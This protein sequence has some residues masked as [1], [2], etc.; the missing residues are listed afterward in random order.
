MCTCKVRFRPV[1]MALTISGTSIWPLV[2]QATDTI[3]LTMTGIIQAPAVSKTGQ[4]AGA[5]AGGNRHAADTIPLTMTGIIQ[6]PAVNQTDAKT[7]VVV[8]GP[9]MIYDGNQNESTVT[10]RN[11]GKEQ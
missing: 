9:R 1:L 3:P 8:D 2:V 7:G 5:V 11:Q 6:A 4:K 10:V